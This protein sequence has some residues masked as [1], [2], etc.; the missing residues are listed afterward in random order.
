MTANEYP[1][2]VPLCRLYERTSKR[3]NPYLTGRLGAARVTILKTDQTDE[4][5]NAIWSLL[6]QEAPAKQDTQH[7]RHDRPAASPADEQAKRDW[8][9]PL[10]EWTVQRGAR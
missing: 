5:G 6:I 2:S 7:Q 4:D 10:D 1:P 9:R 8:Q 3:G